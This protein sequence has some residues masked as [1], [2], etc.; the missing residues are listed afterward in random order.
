MRI[1][2]S[3]PILRV[4]QTVPLI[5]GLDPEAISDLADASTMSELADGEVLFSEGEMANE[6]TFVMSGSIRL[7]CRTSSDVEIVVGY[8][9][10]GDILGEMAVLDPAPR[11][12]TARAAEAAVVLHLPAD[13]FDDFIDQ[14]HPVAKVMLVAIRQMMT[15][16][17]RV[18]NE[19]IAALF[20][21]DAEED[22]NA[23]FQSMVG[24]LR[25]IWS[26]MRSGG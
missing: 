15:H 3:E 14:G 12:A 1:Q 10:A 17:I 16:R 5:K 23:E 4:L 7:T 19:R 25:D 24:R 8:V 20:L 11:S 21:I 18:L 9:Q 13:S 2:A 6:V 26:T 22:V